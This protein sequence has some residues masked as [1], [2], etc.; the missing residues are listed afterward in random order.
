MHALVV[1]DFDSFRAT[2]IGMLQSLGVANVDSS[3]TSAE[4]LRL[5]SARAYDIILCDQNLGKGKTGQQMLEVLRSAPNLNSDSLFVLISAESNKSIIMAAYDCE[6]D[7]YLA[8][9][10]TAQALAQRLNRLLVQRL[11]L[12]PIYKSLKQSDV[13]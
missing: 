2:L 1:D 11:A 6:P 12:A 5:C 3:A 4:A 9:P 8:K 10:I 13:A 7:G